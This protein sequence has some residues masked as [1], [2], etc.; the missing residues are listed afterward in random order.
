MEGSTGAMVFAIGK[1]MNA[2]ETVTKLV[3]KLPWKANRKVVYFFSGLHM[4]RM[5]SMG[6]LHG[7]VWRG[8]SDFHQGCRTRAAEWGKCLH[9]R[10]DQGPILQYRYLQSR[11]ISA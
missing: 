8:N 5:D 4:G 7:D 2:R 11:Y 3:C 10:I 1:T 9:G 6:V